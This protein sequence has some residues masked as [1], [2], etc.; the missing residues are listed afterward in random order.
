[1]TEQKKYNRIELEEQLNEQQKMFCHVFLFNN[2]VQSYMKVYPD[3]EYKSAS[4]SATRLLD[5]VRI[6]AYID[7]IKLDV[8]ELCGV[9]KIK[10]IKEL[11]KIAY[12]SVEHIH[13]GWIELT[14]WENIKKDNPYILTAIESIDTKTEQRTYKTDEDPETDVEIKYI[15][16]VQNMAANHF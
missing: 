5:D 14:D 9:S 6:K 15:M 4:A 1:M 3:C 13:D 8:E 7:F 11:A 16:A 10:N 2:R 12:S